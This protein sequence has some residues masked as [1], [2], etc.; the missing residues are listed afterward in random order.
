MTVVPATVAWTPGKVRL[1]RVVLVL[2]LFAALVLAGKLSGATDGLTADRLRAMVLAAGAWGMLLY[3][4]VFSLGQLVHLPGLLFVIAGILAYGRLWG[5]GLAWIG[6]LSSVSLTFAVARSV[7]GSP[8]AEIRSP[9][10][11]KILSRL[12]TH[13]IWTVLVLRLFLTTSPPVNYTLALSGVRY[14]DY[15]LGSA[16]G[17]LPAIVLSSLFVEHMLR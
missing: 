16:L 3:V 5:G 7:G 17:L 12:E 14:R 13:P 10:V 1:L 4:L 9:R 15:L 11:R 8:L 6:A 2:V